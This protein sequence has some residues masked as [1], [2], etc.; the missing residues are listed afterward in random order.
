MAKQLR[1]SIELMRFAPRFDS[2]SK[3]EQEILDDLIEDYEVRNREGKLIGYSCDLNKMAD[4][5]IKLATKYNKPIKQKA[6]GSGKV[7]KSGPQ[8]SPAL[9]ARTHGT[10]AGSKG[11]REPQTMEEAMMRLREINRR[12]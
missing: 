1:P 4:K 10:A 3:G 9:D 12:K 6:G 8:K 2:M 5:A 7:K 11:D